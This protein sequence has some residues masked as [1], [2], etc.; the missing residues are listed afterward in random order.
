MDTF[1]GM[2]F[3]LFDNGMN[4]LKYIWYQK[5]AVIIAIVQRNICCWVSSYIYTIFIILHKIYIISKY[6]SIESCKSRWDLYL[7]P[8][9]NFSVGWIVLENICKVHIE[10]LVILELSG[11]MELAG[12]FDES[13]QYQTKRKYVKYFNK[14]TFERALLVSLSTRCSKNLMI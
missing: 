7:T 5:K 2:I 13:R 12:N 4:V 9:V 1:W 8:W 10:F 14:Y 6:T 11:V 3:F